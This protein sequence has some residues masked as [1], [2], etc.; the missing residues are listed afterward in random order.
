[1]FT[2]AEFSQAIFYL[3]TRIANQQAN[4]CRAVRRC[5]IGGHRAYHSSVYRKADT[6]ELAWTVVEAAK[7]G[8]GALSIVSAETLVRIAHNFWVVQPTNVTR[9]DIGSNKGGENKPRADQL[10]AHTIPFARAGKFAHTFRNASI[11]RSTS[12]SES[13]CK[14]IAKPM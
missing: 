8:F 6:P 13:W 1:M 3:R 10:N 7:I 5:Q 9:R 12:V 14:H 11:S 2:E 4:V